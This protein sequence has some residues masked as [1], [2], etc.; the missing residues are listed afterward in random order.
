MSNVNTP[1]LSIVNPMVN[2]IVW[3]FI[4]LNI[5]IATAMYVQAPNKTLIIAGSYTA[6]YIWSAIFLTV[7]LTQLYGKITNNWALIRYTLITGLS[8]KVI[9]TYAL[10]V[11]GLSVGFKGIIGVTSLWLVITWVQFSTIRNFPKVQTG[12]GHG[13]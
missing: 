8:I 10:I 7:S 12:M 13:K 2:D 11:L 5:C 3:G 1:K 9:F 4:V 6:S